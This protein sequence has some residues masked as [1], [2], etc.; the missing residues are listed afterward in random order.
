M[1]AVVKRM[2]AQGLSL[3]EIAERT[4]TPPEILKQYAEENA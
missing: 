1:H 2:Q 3:E 4:M